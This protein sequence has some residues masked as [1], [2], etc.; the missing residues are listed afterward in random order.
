MCGSDWENLVKK[1]GSRSVAAGLVLLPFVWPWASPLISLSFRF[2]PFLETRSIKVEVF[3]TVF[4]CATALSSKLLPD[5]SLVAL[6]VIRN[7]VWF[8]IKK[9]WRFCSS[10]TCLQRKATRTLR[11]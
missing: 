3:Q 9:L 1:P 8:R 11:W 6:S 2:L 5:S 4:Q 7:W 10:F